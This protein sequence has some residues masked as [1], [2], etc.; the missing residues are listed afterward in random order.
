MGRAAARVGVIELSA[1]GEPD[2]TDGSRPTGPSVGEGAVVGSAAT[3]VGG[4]LGSAGAL[5]A[6]GET[7]LA[8]GVADVQAASTGLTTKRAVARDRNRVTGRIGFP[9]WAIGVR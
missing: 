8:D 7:G 5:L 2:G 1:G 3:G 4:W 6:G 9:W